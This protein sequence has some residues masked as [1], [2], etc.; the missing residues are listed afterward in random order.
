MRK[1]LRG[2]LV[3]GEPQGERRKISFADF[4]IPLGA[5]KTFRRNRRGKGL[6]L[7]V[8]TGNEK[9]TATSCS[10]PGEGNKCPAA[11]ARGKKRKRKGNG[12]LPIPAPALSYSYPTFYQRAKEPLKPIRE[13][14][15]LTE[16]TNKKDSSVI[17]RIRL[18]SSAKQET[19]ISQVLKKELANLPVS[20]DKISRLGS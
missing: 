17:L 16:I 15:P 10:P 13:K 14:P 1:R 2:P 7:T 6:A 9:S 3:G 11:E 18:K 8:H 5:Q 20:Y 4:I 19:L 12:C